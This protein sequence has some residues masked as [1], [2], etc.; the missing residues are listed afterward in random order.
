MS[1]LSDLIADII[2][3][4]LSDDMGPRKRIVSI[5]S[6]PSKSRAAPRCFYLWLDTLS[7]NWWWKLLSGNQLQI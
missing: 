2:A 3:M 6:T 5:W 7:R 1:E 4:L